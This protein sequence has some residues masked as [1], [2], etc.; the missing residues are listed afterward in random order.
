LDKARPGAGNPEMRH[1]NTSM[2]RCRWLRDLRK[3]RKIR[4]SALASGHGDTTHVLLPLFVMPIP[5]ANEDL[6]SGPVVQRYPVCRRAGN[7]AGSIALAPAPLTNQHCVE[8]EREVGMI[9]P[10]GDVCRIGSVNC[11]GIT[12]RDNPPVNLAVQIEMQ[13]VRN[14]G[15][16]R[17]G[18]RRLCRGERSSGSI[19]RHPRPMITVGPFDDLTAARL[20]RRNETGTGQES[21]K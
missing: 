4:P 15:R 21:Q 6:Q 8:I 13:C 5:A 14:G 17:N 10:S 3:P 18:G 20:Q 1:Q 16:A 11:L 2:R 19:G 7:L 9:I 12:L